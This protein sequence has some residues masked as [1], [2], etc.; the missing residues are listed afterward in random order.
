MAFKYS[1]AWRNAVLDTGSTK[2]TF[3]GGMITLYSGVVPATPD[4]ALSGNTALVKFSVD[5]DGSTGLTL[6]ESAVDGVIVKNASESWSGT[7]TATGTATFFRYINGDDN[8]IIIQGTCGGPSSAADMI[9]ATA[10][11][12]LG[13]DYTL[14]YFSLTHTA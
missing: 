10:D 8:T 3:A 11:I 4:S 1:N 7:A 13:S 14:D 9:L 6:A 5:G 2:D 12:T